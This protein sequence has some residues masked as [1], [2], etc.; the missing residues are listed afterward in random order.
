MTMDRSSRADRVLAGLFD[1][2][3]DARTPDYL[4]A[5]IEHASSR[6]QR[7]VVDVPRKVAPHG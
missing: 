2:L 1:E 5:A 3:A 7:P 6:P 4:E